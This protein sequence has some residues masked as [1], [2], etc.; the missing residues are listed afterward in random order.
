MSAL[1]WTRSIRASLWRGIG[2]LGLLLALGGVVSL[3]S[4]S[5][6]TT[7]VETSFDELQQQVHLTLALS[8]GIAQELLA[9]D[10]YLAGDRQARVLF[11]SLG[12]EVRRTYRQL[13][14]LAGRAP[15]D[16]RLVAGVMREV[17]DAEAHYAMAHRLSDLGRTDEAGARAAAAAPHAQ[18]ALRGLAAISDAE[19]STIAT[20]AARLSRGAERRS[21]IMLVLLG[22]ALLVAA[23]IARRTVRAVAHPLGT[24]VG[25]ARRLGAGDLTARSDGERLPEEFVVLHS[26]MNEAAA[27]LAGVAGL[28]AR[29]AEDVALSANTVAAGAEQI[30]ASASQIAGAMTG[31][32]EG[33]ESNL[34]ALRTVTASL[35]E[36]RGS[37]HEVH[38]GAVEMGGL[39]DAIERSAHEKRGEI[40]TSVRSLHRVRDSVHAAA[41]DV[42]SLKAATTDILRFV[43]EVRGI[44]TQSKLLALNAA[45]E[46]ARAG[47]H[48]RG[49]YVV[50]DEVGQLTQQTQAA[51]QEIARITELVAARID[52]AVG[53]ITNGV[54]RVAEIE[55]LAGELHGALDTIVAGAT[56]TRQA[57][58]RVRELAERN[59]GALAVASDGLGEIDVSAS[60][61]AAAAQE[62]SAATQEQ[63]ASSEEVSAIAAQLMANSTELQAAVAR[64]R[65]DA[66][67]PA[68]LEA[69][70]KA[71]GVV[72]RP[73]QPAAEPAEPAWAGRV[74]PA[75]PEPAVPA[76]SGRF[77]RVPTAGETAARAV[78]AEAAPPAPE[79]AVPASALPST[80]DSTTGERSP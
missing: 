17:A 73:A 26:A 65:L 15:A 56:A 8:T 53:S 60:R 45:I 11:D 31:V 42:N 54:A 39:A 4:T 16:A 61:Y 70:G 78:A 76:W 6:Q 55:R 1:D 48:G 3:W 28:V 14:R 46:A 57:A 19:R 71:E 33:A 63:A 62:V 27:S 41:S 35:D 34:S 58:L 66:S 50:A 25:H 21:W 77:R 67:P 9:A 74:A 75:V 18:A 52:S 29:T 5:E 38:A 13:D 10:R 7:A 22:G 32:S 59:V 51:A 49:F 69:A 44:A 80:A 79:E 37:A 12:F 64:F 68:E 2:A 23:S 30:T 36:L 24:A 40:T 47:E 20:A 43:T 72:V